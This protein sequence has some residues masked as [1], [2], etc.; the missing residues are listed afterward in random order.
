MRF[1]KKK[2]YW[3]I[4]LLYMYLAESVHGRLEILK[5]ITII[6]WIRIGWVI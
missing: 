5:Y 2:N 6:S 1:L 4:I 3:C